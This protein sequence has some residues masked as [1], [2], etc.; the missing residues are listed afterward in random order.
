MVEESVNT[1]N[2]GIKKSLAGS[3]AWFVT[4][5]AV[6]L[7]LGWLFKNNVIIAGRDGWPVVSPLTVVNFLFVGLTLHLL[8]LRHTHL[9]FF[10]HIRTVF[11][12]LI[13]WIFLTS[14]FVI[15]RQL[16]GLDLRPEAYFLPDLQIAMVQKVKQMAF[17]SAL[18]FTFTAF[19]L[20]LEFYNSKLR[21]I[22]ILLSIF[23]LMLSLAVLISYGYNTDVIHNYMLFQGMSFP[24]AFVFFILHLIWLSVQ[25][26]EYVPQNIHKQDRPIYVGFFIIFIAFILLG[27]T[28]SQG[29]IR[30]METHKEQIII[31]ERIKNLEYLIVDLLGAETGGRGYVITADEH[32]LEPFYAAEQKYKSY[33]DTLQVEKLTPDQ[34]VRLREVED[35]ANQKISYVREMVKLRKQQGL[36]KASQY[37]S[38]DKGKEIMD[39]IRRQVND[40]IHAE[41]KY[42]RTQADLNE[43]HSSWT[44]LALIWGTLIAAFSLAS[45]F[46]FYRRNDVRRIAAES[47]IADLNKELQIKLKE[48]ETLNKEMESFS[49]SV[50]HDLRAPLRAMAG[51]GNILLEDLSS[52]LGPSDVDY[53]KRIVAASEKMSRLIDGLLVLSRLSRAH[54]KREMVDVLLIVENLTKDFE[55]V[56]GYRH[57]TFKFEAGKKIW[58]DE[59][60]FQL[61]L[62]NLIGNA[63]KF[64]SKQE[65]PK[66]E[67]GSFIKEKHTVFYVKDN[68]AGFDMK[69]VDKLFGTF[70]RL[71]FEH[72]FQGTGIGLATSRRIVNMHNGEIW[73]E[74]KKNEGAAFYFYFGAMEGKKLI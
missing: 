2:V 57:V 58:A 24:T 53:L 18:C 40:M 63:W 60:L 66:V 64:T 71:H 3:L 4:G 37:I 6:A 19:V 67:I 54:T 68:G 26:V 30:L 39:H 10:S 50:S 41:M 38:I 32:Y 72:E 73:A 34:K 36:Q 74:G 45:C 33:I 55:R 47:R 35:L 28:S 59:I 27:L 22:K 11:Y 65:S 17:A 23:T 42:S 7:M 69:Y 46:V 51:F 62:Q 61:L 5:A 20:T 12:F 15:L 49:Y 56:E 29:L 52:K 70:Q 21:V 8:N 31:Q 1:K 48:T 43:K 44:L 14:G 13:V 9:S 25:I 16:M